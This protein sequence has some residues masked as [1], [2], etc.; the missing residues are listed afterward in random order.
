MK[1]GGRCR[2]G[3]HVSNMNGEFAFFALWLSALGGFSAA[4]NWQE[5]E[6]DDSGIIRT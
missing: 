1:I 6:H 5:D 2:E 3:L 4:R